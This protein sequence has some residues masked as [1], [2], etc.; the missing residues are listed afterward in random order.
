M[1]GFMLNLE[2]T[3]KFLNLENETMYVKKK[4]SKLPDTDP[5]FLVSIDCE[6]YF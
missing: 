2:V 5:L 1:Y 3:S 4:T 6:I